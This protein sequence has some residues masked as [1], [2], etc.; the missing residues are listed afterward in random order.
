MQKRRYSKHSFSCFHLLATFLPIASWA[1]VLLILI[2]KPT[3]QKVVEIIRKN[4]IFNY[5]YAKSFVCFHS[6]SFYHSRLLFCSFM[7]SE[8]SNSLD[9]YQKHQTHRFILLFYTF[10]LYFCK[11][12]TNYWV[13]SF[14]VKLRFSVVW[15]QGFF[16]LKCPFS[17]PVF[18]QS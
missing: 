2:Q 8:S 11:V 4:V 15:F 17:F 10:V 9:P 1:I 13:I 7:T 5:S 3:T 6:A 18:L 14:P 16:C 12:L